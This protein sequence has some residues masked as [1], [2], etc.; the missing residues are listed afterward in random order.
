ML[1]KI[2]NPLNELCFSYVFEQEIL[3]NKLIS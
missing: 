1:L 2:G 3:W